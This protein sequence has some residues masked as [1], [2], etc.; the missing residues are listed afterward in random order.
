MASRMRDTLHMQ[1]ETVGMTETKSSS[2]IKISHLG[3]AGW[4]TY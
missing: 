2:D 4:L 1:N 3:A